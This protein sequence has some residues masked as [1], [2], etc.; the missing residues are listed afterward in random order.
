MNSQAI[1]DDCR[2][3]H[4]PHATHSQ[5]QSLHRSHC[6]DDMYTMA[7]R[8]VVRRKDILSSTRHR[9][10]FAARDTEHF[11][12]ASL[13][14]LSCVVVVFSEPRMVV[15]ESNYLLR[16]PTAGWHIYGIRLLHKFLSPIGSSSTE[17]WSNHK[18]R[19]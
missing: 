6:T 4:M 12:T 19:H 15:H 13:F 17:F 18:I 1:D 8:R 7:H 3:I 2:Q 9:F 5:V 16:R 14:Y 11:L 10:S